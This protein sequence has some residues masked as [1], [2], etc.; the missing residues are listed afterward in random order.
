MEVADMY[1]ELGSSNL[2]C[3]RAVVATELSQIS[4]IAH[5]RESAPA[6]VPPH[7]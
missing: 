5:D 3:H 7:I 6:V 1:E 2:W 4:A